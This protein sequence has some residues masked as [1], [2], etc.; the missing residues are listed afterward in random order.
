MSGNAVPPCPHFVV[1]RAAKNEM[2]KSENGLFFKKYY[3][4]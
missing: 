4:K 1:M 3:A 2:L